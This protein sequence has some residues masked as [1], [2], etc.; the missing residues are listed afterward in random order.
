MPASAFV[1]LRC[2]CDCRFHAYQQ[3]IC[4]SPKWMPL[5]KQVDPPIPMIFHRVILTKHLKQND[6]GTFM[7][8]KFLSRVSCT[9]HGTVTRTCS[10]RTGLRRTPAERRVLLHLLVT[11]SLP[12]F[13]LVFKQVVLVLIFHNL[14]HS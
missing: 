6:W 3:N 11:V 12:F 4:S 2:G 14:F 7:M 13:G 9:E 10:A 5:Q 1:R 8:D